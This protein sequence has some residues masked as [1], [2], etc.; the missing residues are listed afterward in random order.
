TATEFT[1]TGG[2]A[3]RTRHR[4]PGGVPSTTPRSSLPESVSMAFCSVRGSRGVLYTSHPRPR[5]ARASTATTALIVFSVVIPMVFSTPSVRETN[6]TATAARTLFGSACRRPS[7]EWVCAG[8][9]SL[10]SRRQM[11]RLLR[12]PVCP[13]EQ[14]RGLCAT[15]PQFFVPRLLLVHP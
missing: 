3:W 15:A 14:G 2:G 4:R 5:P 8:R 7:F 10:F 9:S 11:L 13:V 12:R 6:V 1:D